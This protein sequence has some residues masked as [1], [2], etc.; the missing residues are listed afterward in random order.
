MHSRKKGAELVNADDSR[1]TRLARPEPLTEGEPRR[2][3]AKVAWMYHVRGMKQGEIAGRLGLSQ[4]RV[5]RLLETAVAAGI[6]RTTV[7]VPDGLHAELEERLEARYGLREAHVFDV[8]DGADDTGVVSDLG[9]MLASRLESNPLEAEVIGFTSW[10]RSLRETVGSMNQPSQSSAK[11]VVELLGDVGPPTVQ[12]QA[13]QL[14]QQLAA[15]TGAEPRFLRVP[16]VVS[17]AEVRQAL[18]DR[19]AHAREALALLDRVD[20]AL[21]GIGTC[22]IVPPL[23]AGDNFF[24]TE[25]FEY[26]RSLGAVGQ[27]NLRFIAADGSP[28]FS[29]LDELIVGVTLEQLKRC[30]RTLAVAGGPSKYP[31]IKAA[32]LGGF[33]NTL[34]TDADTARHLLSET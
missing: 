3:M 5:S 19:D 20:L 10:S 9:R 32:V 17:S 7:V 6:V 4:S 1:S 26:A 2:L 29:E 13:A 21:V 18:L 12:H 22:E 31:A 23:Q 15:L 28:V 33:V 34:I 8:G 24:T 27:V 30:Q 16:G 25:Q 14:T 11:Y